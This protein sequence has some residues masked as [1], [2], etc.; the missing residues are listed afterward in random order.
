MIKKILNLVAQGRTI[1]EISQI[2]DMEY[3]AVMGMLEHL[4]KMGYLEE[5]KRNE[6]EMS[7]CASCKMYKK[8]SKK[9]LKIYYLTERGKKLIGQE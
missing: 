2:M 8:C 9:E 1:Y 4:V 7:F 5:R 6:K 3:S